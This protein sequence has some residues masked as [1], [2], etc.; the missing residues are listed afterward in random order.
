MR[1]RGPACPAAA[2][3]LGPRH[4]P[5]Q[6]VESAAPCAPRV[7][8]RTYRTAPVPQ[9]KDAL[10]SFKDIAGIDQVGAGRCAALLV[11]RVLE[12]PA[13]TTPGRLTDAA[14]P[15]AGPAPV[16]RAGPAAA[17]A[18]AVPPPG[19]LRSN[20]PSAVKPSSVANRFLPANPPLPGQ[21]FLSSR[22]PPAGQ[23][24]DHRDRA[25][26]SGPSPLPVPGRA[27]P[28]RHAAGGAA[29]WAQL[30]THRGGE[31]AGCCACVAPGAL[32]SASWV[33]L[34]CGC[35]RGFLPPAPAPAFS[36]CVCSL[37][38]AGE[39]ATQ[40]PPPAPSLP[41][42]RRHR[43]DAAGK[44]GGGGGGG[45]LLF[46]WWVMA[47]LICGS[48][49]G[50]RGG[51]GYGGEGRVE[52]RGGA[53]REMLGGH[54]CSAPPGASGGS[55]S[56]R[57]AAAAAAPPRLARLPPSLPP[58]PPLTSFLFPLYFPAFQPAP[59]SWRCLWGWAPRGCATSSSRPEPT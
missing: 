43:Q 31:P 38:F 1:V 57:G 18:A 47:A 15:A 49:H 26:P 39:V 36:C 23:G 30:G 2:A 46:H 24:G 35:W 37:R 42:A 54:P 8:P 51:V 44:G 34:V 21:T 48:L 32:I 5:S 13:P 45:A 27:L 19:Q 53:G 50:G 25:V 10:F 9:A 12:R 58:S 41:A 6:R 4:P 20:L 14:A 28:R 22:F 16:P 29:R 40:T 11:L 33:L 56:T 3:A 7:L 59:S 55:R 17:A 52:W